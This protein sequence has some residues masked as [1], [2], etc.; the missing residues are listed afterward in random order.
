M[1]IVL[2]LSQVWYVYCQGDSMWMI[3]RWKQNTNF[4]ELHGD[5]QSHYE[6]LFTLYAFGSKPFMHFKIS[7]KFHKMSKYA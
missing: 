6:M 1:L 2:V 4:D 7:H 3:K 5:F